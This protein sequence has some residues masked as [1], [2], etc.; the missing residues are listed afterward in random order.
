MWS[1]IFWQLLLNYH[2][3]FE[4]FGG[5]AILKT[6]LWKG[7]GGLRSTTDDHVD[8]WW[9]HHSQAYLPTLLERSSCL[10]KIKLDRYGLSCDPHNLVSNTYWVSGALTNISVMLKQ[11]S[12]TYWYLG[13][14]FS[15]NFDTLYSSLG[16]LRHLSFVPVSHLQR[17]PCVFNTRE[18]R[19]AD[20]ALTF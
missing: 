10:N 16:L 3:V 14:K 11:S 15:L 7:G 19:V 9:Y 8:M 12:F 6:E 17:H 1:D 4:C 13:R 18:S 5:R 20:S 2:C